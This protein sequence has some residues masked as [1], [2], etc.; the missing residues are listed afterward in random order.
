MVPYLKRAAAA[1]HEVHRRRSKRLRS[2]LAVVDLFEEGLEVVAQ[3][4]TV[5][6]LE[7]T[8]TVDLVLEQLALLVELGEQR[9]LLLLGVGDD[10]VALG[11][12]LGDDLRGR[13]PAWRWRTPRPAGR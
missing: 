12:G 3:V 6:G 4:R 10:R 5:L 2:V 1:H 9:V 7:G 8:Q 11:V 13:G